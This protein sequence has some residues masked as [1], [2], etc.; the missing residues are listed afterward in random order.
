MTEVRGGNLGRLLNPTSVAIVGASEKRNMSNIA[1]AHLRAAPVT[2]HLVTPSVPEAYG[3]PTVASL[4]DIDGPVDAVLSLVGAERA[5]DVVADAAAIG[6]GGV[7]VVASGFA[8][9]GGSGTSLQDELRSRALDAGLPVIGPNCTGFSNVT[10]GTNCFTGTAVDVRAGGIALVSSSGYLMRSAMVAARERNLGVRIAISSGNEAVTTLSDYLD[11]FIA[12]PETSTICVIIE[13][14][15]EPAEFFELAARA[16]AASKPLIVLKLGRSDRA[17]DIVKSHTGALT[18]QAWL[19]DV[20]FRSSGVMPARNVDDLLDLASVVSQLPRDR[21]KPVERAAVIGTSGGVAALVSDTIDPDDIELPTLDGLRADLA[22]HIEG[23][24]VVNPLD[25]T[26]LTLARPGAVEA[27]MGTLVA[28]PEVDAMVACWWI[29]DDDEDR[30]RT[31][32]DPIAQLDTTKPIVMT[33]LE[34]SRVGRWSADVDIPGVAFCGSIGGAARGLRAMRELLRPLPE[35]TPTTERVPRPTNLVDSDLGPIVSFD[36]AMGLLAAAGVPVAPWW[37]HH[38]GLAASSADLDPDIRYVVKLADVPHRT[39]LGAVRIGVAHYDLDVV[40]A[41][42]VALAHR[43]DVPDTV[44]VQAMASGAGEA[45]IGIQA[46]TEVGDVVVAGLGGI[47]VELTRNVVGRMLPVAAAD[48]DEMLDEFGGETVF[49]GIRGAEPW[50]RTALADAI[51]AAARFGESAAE[52]LETM[53][54]NPLIAGPDGAVAV[55]V[56]MVVRS[57]DS[58]AGH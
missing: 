15:R 10:M 4:Q 43:E 13:K 34:R 31:L 9:A 32:L 28:S 57:S 45:F 47:F 44:V 16:R 27:V 12:D 40:A 36:E 41:E 39:E 14:L 50:N 11:Y 51:S 53:D 20:A 54:L 1:A 6:A 48:V 19:Y 24:H 30:S 21:W 8:E 49:K 56:L 38:A 37:I 26:G 18:G 35:R 29:S 23:V 55:D 25:L 33:T 58:A 46:G 42:L 5:L 22:Q 3:Q 17:R 7:V 52:W 2:L